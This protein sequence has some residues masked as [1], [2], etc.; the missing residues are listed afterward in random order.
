MATI[1]QSKSV[2]FYQFLVAVL[3]V[4]LAAATAMAI[5]FAV[6]RTT[7]VVPQ[8]NHVTVAPASPEQNCSRPLV[9]C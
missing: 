9:P 6:Q 4:A 3:G 5:F 2:Q 7:E 1:T 8:D